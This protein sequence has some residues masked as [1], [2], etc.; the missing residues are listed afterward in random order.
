MQGSNRG[1]ELT[2]WSKSCWAAWVSRLRCS[3]A[4]QLF[5]FPSRS[6]LRMKYLA[7]HKHTHTPQQWPGFL[8][9]DWSQTQLR[10]RVLALGYHSGSAGVT[11]WHY[12]DIAASV[13]V[14]LIIFM[15]PFAEFC[16]D[17]CVFFVSCHDEG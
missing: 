2:C 13:C 9:R 15:N 16:T 4:G 17:L 1:S 3:P 5:M 12:Q 11:Q 6:A 14:S 8:Q 7:W 10:A